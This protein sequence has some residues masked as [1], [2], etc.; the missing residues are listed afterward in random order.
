M[1][2]LLAGA[3]ELEAFQGLSD[4]D[5][6]QLPVLVNSAVNQHYKE[7]RNLLPPV[8]CSHSVGQSLQPGI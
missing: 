5:L 8:T 2:A 6:V 3:L 1:N 7:I 4:R